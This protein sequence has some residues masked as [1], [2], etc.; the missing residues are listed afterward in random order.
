MG[1][2][3]KPKAGRSGAMMWKE[4]LAGLVV[5]RGEMV[6]DHSRWEEG[7]PW[8]R[9]RGTASGFEERWWMKWRGIGWG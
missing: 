6:L 1:G 4:R 2:G 5:V 8:R 7:Q 9:R 3:E